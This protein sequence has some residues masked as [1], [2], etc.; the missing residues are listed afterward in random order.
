MFEFLEKAATGP[1]RVF[2][3]L[4]KKARKP[5]PLNPSISFTGSAVPGSAPTSAASKVKTNQQMNK[6]TVAAKV[7][8][9][10]PTG[11]GI[12]STTVYKNPSNEIAPP[13]A[14]VVPVPKTKKPKA[15]KPKASAGEVSPP[16]PTVV[17]PK[18]VQHEPQTQPSAAEISGQQAPA[19]QIER[20]VPQAPPP[21]AAPARL[22]TGGYAH[23]NEIK[24]GHIVQFPSVV[25]VHGTVTRIDPETGTAYVKMPSGITL[26]IPHHKI[27]SHG[28]LG[29]NNTPILHYP[30]AKAVPMIEGAAPEI[31]P[32][33]PAKRPE[34]EEGIKQ[35]IA[36]L[37]EPSEKIAEEPEITPEDIRQRQLAL[38]ER[39][40]NTSKAYAQRISPGDYVSYYYESPVT[41]ELQKKHGIVKINPAHGKESTI[42]PVK[43][44]V[45]D[46]ETGLDVPIPS[47]HIYNYSSVHPH[48]GDLETFRYDPE[49]KR[50]VRVTTSPTGQQEPSK[51]KPEQPAAAIERTT[52]TPDELKRIPQDVAKIHQ[53]IESGKDVP[54]EVLEA[55]EEL[56]EGKNLAPNAAIVEEFVNTP[57]A[58]TPLKMEHPSIEHYQNEFGKTLFDP[59]TLINAKNSLLPEAPTPL[60]GFAAEKQRNAISSLKNFVEE[61]K[62]VPGMANILNRLTVLDS[63]NDSRKYL[64]FLGS[65]AK[66]AVEEAKGPT[67]FH[68]V[69]P[70]DR[71]IANVKHLDKLAD[72]LHGAGLVTPQTDQ[73]LQILGVLLNEAP[74]DP[75]VERLFARLHDLAENG[76]SDP[77]F[78]FDYIANELA[79]RGA[80]EEERLAEASP[81][82][83]EAAQKLNEILNEPKT[84]SQQ[85]DEALKQIVPLLQKLNIKVD[86][87]PEIPRRGTAKR[88]EDQI[89]ASQQVKQIFN[90]QE[91]IGKQ[92]NQLEDEA[93]KNTLSPAESKQAETLRLARDLKIL[94]DKIRINEENMRVLRETGVVDHVRGQNVAESVYSSMLSNT[95]AL[96]D[97]YNELVDQAKEH[98]INSKHY[99]LFKE[100]KEKEGEDREGTRLRH[101]EFMQKLDSKLDELR[102]N[103]VKNFEITRRHLLSSSSMY[104]PEARS[105][106]REVNDLINQHLQTLAKID[107]RVAST[108][109]GRHLID[110]FNSYTQRV[111]EIQ[112]QRNEYA[113]STTVKSLE[114]TMNAEKVIARR[115]IALALRKSFYND[116]DDESISHA[117]DLLGS[118]FDDVVDRIF[119]RFNNLPLEVKKGWS[120]RTVRS[121]IKSIVKENAHVVTDMRHDFTVPL[122]KGVI[123][124]MGEEIANI[125]TNFDMAANK[126]KHFYTIPLSKS[127]PAYNPKLQYFE[128]DLK[129]FDRDEKLTAPRLEAAITELDKEMFKA[130]LTTVQLSPNR[131]RKFMLDNSLTTAAKMY[132]DGVKELYRRL[133]EIKRNGV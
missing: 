128:S 61:N 68:L 64:E 110:A 12:E 50:M 41:G 13:P 114:E 85:Y 27:Q 35:R 34:V 123:R 18:I 17:P 122:D 25:P 9:V 125:A 39:V 53:M 117:A 105:D 49:L 79:E 60:A 56:A 44:L 88:V 45:T 77:E 46:E 30:P 32:Q 7:P 59:Q 127:V 96:V 2:D 78:R 40:R 95:T 113:N 58:A 75:K 121:L 109:I 84:T 15:K 31:Q 107:P 23:F 74:G 4:L 91:Q 133:F 1:S 71:D 36:N 11:G 8:R 48:T 28:E 54:P 72:Y 62:D 20:P 80:L 29:P 108:V 37:R 63:N 43:F 98:G 42:T 5:L 33:A 3:N 131:I 73:K 111:G 24:P 132:N 10:S 115:D 66:Q 51:V 90:E 97:R 38:I 129:V 89:Q 14:P 21:A 101:Q 26:K 106:L 67:T 16:L 94:R 126:F 119:T 70:T 118:Y 52:F 22:H 6:E 103:A 104:S 86:I 120:R 93:A 82:M 130:G 19:R 47:S 100:E 76:S 92:I 57:R 112:E 83:A 102:N 55:K 69:L 116:K 124:E 99:E 87:P 65:A 81:E